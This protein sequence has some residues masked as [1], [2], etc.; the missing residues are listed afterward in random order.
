[1]KGDYSHKNTPWVFGLGRNSQFLHFTEVVVN[2]AIPPAN[3]TQL[4]THKRAI[5]TLSR[6]ECANVYI[7]CKSLYLTLGVAKSAM[8]HLAAY[9]LNQQINDNEGKDNKDKW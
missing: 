4:W 3:E 5:V 2:V 7:Y 9:K 6:N 1:M 8:K